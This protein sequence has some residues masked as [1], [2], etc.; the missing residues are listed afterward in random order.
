MEWALA[1]KH[2]KRHL[3][4]LNYNISKGFTD[5][6]DSF[7]TKDIHDQE[8]FLTH[9]DMHVELTKLTQGQIL[10]LVARRR[11][12][13]TPYMQSLMKEFEID[14]EDF[15]KRFRN[16]TQVGYAT[17]TRSFFFKMYAGLL[18]GNK[19]LHLFGYVNSK[20]CERCG[21]PEEDT[22]HMLVEC[23]RVKEFRKE[24]YHKVQNKFSRWEELLG[25]EDN[26]YS[27]ILL[28]MNRF[29]YQRKFLRL[30]LVSYDFLAMVRMEEHIE[31]EIAIK[32]GLTSKHKRKWSNIHLTGL[33]S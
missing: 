27:F 28:Q 10:K 8:I 7:K 4:N 30:P 25:T 14:E 20:S 22:S 23:P 5:V 12:D 21:H 24:I 9:D 16:I 3:K 17:K 29:I 2:I 26:A 18:Y 31:R 6:E 33:F 15:A 1:T 13:T 11:K 19:K 32:N